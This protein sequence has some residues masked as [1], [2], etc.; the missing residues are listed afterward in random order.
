MSN[1]ARM[2]ELNHEEI[3]KLRAKGVYYQLP[4]DDEHRDFDENYDCLIGPYG[5]EVALLTEPED[6]TW[7]RDG[8]DVVHELNRQQE[9]IAALEAEVGRLRVLLAQ[10]TNDNRFVS[11]GPSPQTVGHEIGY[12]LCR[13]QKPLWN[14]AMAAMHG[15]EPPHA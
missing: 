3:Q 4:Y 8:A 11:T 13:I 2:S 10:V 12:H 9:R 5:N 7:S 15:E 6:R 1:E 14:K